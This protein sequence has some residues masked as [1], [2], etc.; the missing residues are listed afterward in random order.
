MCGILGYSATSW[1]ERHRANCVELLKQSKIRGLHACGFS[2]VSDNSLCVYKNSSPQGW[3]EVIKAIPHEL[4]KPSLIA[5][6]RYSTSSLED[7]QPVLAQGLA[8]SH[9]GVISQAS[10]TLWSSLF[11]LD[12]ESK[13][14][15]ELIL[16]A[17]LDNGEHPLIRFPNASIAVCK[18]DNLG[19]IEAYRN[20][21]RP[22]ALV[23]GEDYVAFASTKDI[24]RR[25][26]GVSDVRQASINTVY[27]VKDG[28][29][30]DTLSYYDGRDDLQ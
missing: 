8:V 12:T 19:Q 11:G 6:C 14:D 27:K 13:C 4:K 20:H 3:T 28:K 21:L 15:S 25:A 22:L 24:L 29:L 17:H 7:N 1:N 30:D 9:N 5:H 16:R 10:P 26:L 18:I 2:Y 23:V